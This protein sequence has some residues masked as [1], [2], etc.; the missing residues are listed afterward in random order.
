MEELYNRLKSLVESMEDDVQKAAGGNK[1]A[2]TRV[3]KAMQDVKNTAQELRVKVLENREDEPFPSL[4]QDTKAESRMPPSLLFDISEI[5]L[6]RPRYGVDKIEAINPHRGHM[7]LLDEILYES[8]DLQRYV[9]MKHVREDEFWVPGHIPGR[10]IFPGVLMIEAAAQ[11]ASF[12]CLRRMEG[13]AFMGFTGA[14]DIK[15]RG[16]VSPGDDLL[17]LCDQVEFRQRRCVCKTQGLVKGVLVYEGTI[18]GMPL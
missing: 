2:G 10:P 4:S 3:R 5:D 13:L 11:L 1:A 14:D 16:Q 15:F 7:R 6:S 8:D 18:T 17:L 9:A 12:S